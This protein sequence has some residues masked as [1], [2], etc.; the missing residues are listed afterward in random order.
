MSTKAFLGAWL[1][2]LVVFL[3]IDGVWLGL[4]AKQFYRE[5]LGHLMRDSINFPV[6]AAFYIIYTAALVYLCSG[7]G[8]RDNSAWSAVIAGALL[9]VAAYGTYDI[10]NLATLRDWPVTLT[11]VDLAW[12]TTLT[13]FVSYVG[14]RVAAYMTG[15]G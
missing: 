1:S 6:A 12:G 7:M 8:V 4:I 5:Q 10:T 9:G 13:A 3:I 11:I 2:S 15:S 14:Y